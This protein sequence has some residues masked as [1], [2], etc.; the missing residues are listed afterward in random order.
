M[1]QLRN[2]HRGFGSLFPTPLAA[3]VYREVAEAGVRKPRMRK[4]S[5][6]CPAERHLASDSGYKAGLDFILQVRQARTGITKA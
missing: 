2:T 6:A 5:A 4:T 3:D 1:R